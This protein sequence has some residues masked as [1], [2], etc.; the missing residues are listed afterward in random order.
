MRACCGVAAG[1]LS[2]HH[3]PRS[4]G[5]LESGQRQPFLRMELGICQQTWGGGGALAGGVG[6]RLPVP[7]MHPAPTGSL[8]VRLCPGMWEAVLEAGLGGFRSQ[9]APQGDPMRQWGFL[10]FAD[11]ETEAQRF[12]SFTQIQA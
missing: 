8:R 9:V 4:L 6:I 2:L 7:A 10:S 5:R 11:E 12:S 1:E 3:S